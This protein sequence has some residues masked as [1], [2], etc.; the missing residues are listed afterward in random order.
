MTTTPETLSTRLRAAA[1][2]IAFQ[3][4]TDPHDDKALLREAA[5]ELETSAARRAHFGGLAD[6]YAR[7]SAHFFDLLFKIAALDPDDTQMSKTEFRGKVRELA[8]QRMAHEDPIAV[9]LQPLGDCLNKLMADPGLNLECFPLKPDGS[10]QIEGEGGIEM[11]VRLLLLARDR[12]AFAHGKHLS[13]SH[14]PA[15]EMAAEGGVVGGETGLDLTV[16]ADTLTTTFAKLE[17]WIR[18]D[19]PLDDGEPH[20]IL[21]TETIGDLDQLAG[22]LRVLAEDA[23]ITAGRCVA[24]LEY[25]QDHQIAVMEDAAVKLDLIA[26]AIEPGYT[27][28]AG[29]LGEV[30]APGETPFEAA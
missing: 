6:R 23:R 16:L 7:E 15:L 5:R 13:T 4:R 12:G 21:M 26:A 24:A 22:E 30:A 20:L 25:S 14:G 17:Q 1:D 28:P 2:D 8:Q 9:H 29:L 18:S 27:S 3:G 11:A 10:R 19:G